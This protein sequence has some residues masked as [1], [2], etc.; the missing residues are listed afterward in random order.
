MLSYVNGAEFLLT[1]ATIVLGASV[2][3]RVAAHKR[4]ALELKHETYR[5]MLE[6]GQIE[7]HVLEQIIA[8][9][10][11]RRLPRSWPGTMS[12]GFLSRLSFLVGWLSIFVGIGLAI[13]AQMQ[14]FDRDLMT[15]A[16]IVGLAGLGLASLP[17]AWR[18]V[19]AKTAPEVGRNG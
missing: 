13:A 3:A 12:P 8:G 18:E 7:R 10:E 14:R 2:V 1:I 4:R 17:M 11:G 9:I 16:G 6:S 19:H 5:C 15:A